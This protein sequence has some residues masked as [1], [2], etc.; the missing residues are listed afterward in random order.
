MQ[1]VD[2]YIQK[3][4]EILPSLEGKRILHLHLGVGGNLYELEKQA[5]NFIDFGDLADN[6]GRRP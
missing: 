2:Q 3:M 5:I 4:E 6:K 1:G